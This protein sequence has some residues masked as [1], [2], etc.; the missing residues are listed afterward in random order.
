MADSNISLHDWLDAAVIAVEETAEMALACRAT[1]VAGSCAE[2]DGAC[3]GSHIAMFSNAGSLQVSLISTPQGC[4]TLG[5]E[6][7]GMATDEGELEGADLAD[8]FGEIANLV[9]GNIKLQLNDKVSGLSLGLPVFISGQIRRQRGGQ[10]QST[11][12]DIGSVP[13]RVEVASP[14]TCAK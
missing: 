14:T 13:A 10:V 6:L 9:A 7:L 12:L 11:R 8:A 1:R 3:C 2:L 4:A 5:R